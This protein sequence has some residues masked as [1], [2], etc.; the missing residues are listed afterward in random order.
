MCKP[1]HWS[2]KELAL[3]LGKLD[4]EDETY[5][6][7]HRI[8]LFDQKPKGPQNYPRVYRIQ[9]DLAG[10]GTTLR[11]LYERRIRRTC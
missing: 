2:G 9:G 11:L 6:N 1:D 3:F 5:F 8:D 4:N 10:P 7:G